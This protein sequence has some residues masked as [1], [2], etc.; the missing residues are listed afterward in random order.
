MFHKDHCNVV[1]TCGGF[2]KFHKD[3]CTVK[4]R[5]AKPKDIE[6]EKEELVPC[7]ATIL[8]A[9]AKILIER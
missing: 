1:T 4:V 7:P 2:G 5:E 6:E 3:H 9:L 8:K